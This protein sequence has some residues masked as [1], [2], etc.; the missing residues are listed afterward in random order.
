MKDEFPPELGVRGGIEHFKIEQ[1]I[2]V[3]SG[4]L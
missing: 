2:G 3:R 4:Y 1:E